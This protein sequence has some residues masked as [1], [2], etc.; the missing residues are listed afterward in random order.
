ML[1][2]YF[3]AIN[4]GDIGS[5]VDCVSADATVKVDGGRDGVPPGSGRAAFEAWLTQ[6]MTVGTVTLVPLVA[7]RRDQRVRV[8]LA[9]S[10]LARH[11]GAAT[12][13]QQIDYTIEQD[14]ITEVRASGIR[15][16]RWLAPPSAPLAG[17]DGDSRYGRPMP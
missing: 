1:D 8:E 15:Q 4:A 17:S 3:T 13:L 14:R 7:E 5:A 2:A 9:V 12:M 10:V 11:S 6:E 16:L